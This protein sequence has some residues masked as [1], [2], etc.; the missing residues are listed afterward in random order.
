MSNKTKSGQ[1]AKQADKSLDD[2][3]VAK[4][5]SSRGSNKQ[6]EQHTEIETKGR[7]QAEAN[8]KVKEIGGPKG[9]EPTRYGDWE[10]KGR[11]YDF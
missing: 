11:C 9:L 4:D 2:Q 6:A 10:A 8:A 7:A 3:N 1:A 5:Q